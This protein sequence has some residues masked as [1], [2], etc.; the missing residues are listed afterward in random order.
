MPAI[1]VLAPCGGDQTACVNLLGDQH[2]A[3][4][5]EGDAPGQVET[6]HLSYGEGRIR[7]GF[8]FARI[9]LRIR[10]AR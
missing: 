2:I 9:A 10:R 7:I 6:S 1:S 8:L 4:G 3:I 5:E